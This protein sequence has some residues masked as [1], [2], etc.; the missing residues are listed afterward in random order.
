MSLGTQA[1]TLWGQRHWE[2]K[3]FYD[4]EWALQL[5]EKEIPLNQR[6]YLNL[7]LEEYQVEFINGFHVGFRNAYRDV[8]KKSCYLWNREYELLLD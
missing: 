5:Y 3:E 2:E 4:W 6:Y 7:E 8:F 1:G